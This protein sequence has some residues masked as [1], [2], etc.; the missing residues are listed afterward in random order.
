MSRFLAYIPEAFESIWRN[1]SRS[2]LSAL[3]MIIGIASVIAVLGLSQ[4]ASNG[5]KQQIASGGDPGFII[6][7]DRAQDNPAAATLYY[8]DATLLQSYASGA[9]SR[10]IPLY[11]GQGNVPRIYRITVSGKSDFIAVNTTRELNANSGF[12]V[13]SGRLIDPN[14][15][16]AGANVA[17]LSHDAAAKLFPNG[18][19]VDRT[20]NIGSQRVTVIG[21]VSLKAN[22]S[23]SLVGETIWVPYTTMHRIAP[24]PIDFIEFWPVS[25]TQNPVD[26]IAAARAAMRRIHPL[27]E[28]TI[29]DAVAINAIFVNV[30]S[31][32]GVGLTF[33]GGVALFVAGVGIMNIML[34]SVSERT[35]EIGIR[36]SIGANAQ[37]ISIQ[38]LVEATLL[39]LGGGLIGSLIGVVIVMFMQPV[40]EQYLGAAPVPWVFVIGIAAGF[41]LAV[42]IGFGSYP[43]ARAGKLDPVEALRG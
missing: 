38:F 3:G 16:A 43:A 26:V 6:S 31:F 29:Q 22:L 28:Y 40:V 27:G 34:V 7:V 15:V 41:S 12:T 30:L 17:I 13:D 14:D 18:D 8:R 10:A 24:G 42:G 33:I 2:A 32:I 25:R 20:I 35:R 11:N 37:E 19:I 1:R 5:I 21:V 36:K 4:A 9:V 39:S 23:R